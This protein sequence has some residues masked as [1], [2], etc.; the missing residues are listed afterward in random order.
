[1]VPW[2]ASEVIPEE[3]GTRFRFRLRRGI[4]FHD[5][6]ALTARDVRFSFERLLHAGTT[7][8]KYLLTPIRG[9]QRLLDRLT[10]DL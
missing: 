10:T 5:G 6:R 8:G 7:A 2:L 9:A 1:M 4:R 3:G